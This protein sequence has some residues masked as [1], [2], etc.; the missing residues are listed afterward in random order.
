MEKWECRLVDLEVQVSV[1]F[2]SRTFYQSSRNL[3]MSNTRRKCIPLQKA[4]LGKSSKLI[5]SMT[6]QLLHSIKRSHTVKG[7]KLSAYSNT[8]RMCSSIMHFHTQRVMS[9]QSYS[10]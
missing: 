10:S 8:F 6:F 1:K 5:N 9:S 4:G 2:D 7:S 3:Y